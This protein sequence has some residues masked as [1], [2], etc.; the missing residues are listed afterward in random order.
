MKFINILENKICYK[1]SDIEDTYESIK[2]IETVKTKGGKVNL[3]LNFF[4]KKR[5]NKVGY[6]YLTPFLKLAKKNN[7]NEKIIKEILYLEQIY[8]VTITGIVLEYLN[9]LNK[10]TR[11]LSIANKKE[12][13][14]QN[15]KPIMLERGFEKYLNNT[16]NKAHRLLSNLEFLGIIERSGDMYK[17]K[18]YLPHFNLFCVDLFVNYNDKPNYPIEDIYRNEFSK[19]FLLSARVIDDYLQKMNSMN[20]INLT[21]RADLNYFTFKIKDIEELFNVQ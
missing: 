21:K 5:I 7:T 18:D 19:A 13:I 16:L 14:Y 2:N 8:S 11:T 10:T 12:L 1:K 17:F 20:I 4:E 6:Y 9:Q 15:I 3:F